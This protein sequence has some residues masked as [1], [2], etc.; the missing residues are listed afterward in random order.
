MRTQ[1]I[2]PSFSGKFVIPNSGDN[3]KVNYLYNKVSK[4]VKDNNISGDF[5]ND[6]IVLTTDKTQEKN[7]F[8]SLKEL[9]IK[10]FSLNE[11]K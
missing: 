5:H 3:K 2:T 7:L 11:K 9:G 8:N 10:I 6:K 4:I 1:N